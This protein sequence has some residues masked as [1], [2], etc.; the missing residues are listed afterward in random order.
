[1]S[2]K[3]YSQR[4]L[5]GDI[6]HYDA[7]GKKIVKAGTP[8]NGDLTDENDDLVDDTMLYFMFVR[9]AAR[10]RHLGGASAWDDALTEVTADY[11][12]PIPGA[13]Q[14]LITVLKIM[15]TAWCASKLQQQAL[16]MIH[17]TQNNI[18]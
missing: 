16:T 14:K 2:K 13:R 17:E 18:I 15:L 1:M 7:N 12:E 11:A 9:L 8:L 5:F 10:A 4:G 6:N 3:G